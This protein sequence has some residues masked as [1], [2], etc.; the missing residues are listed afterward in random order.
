MMAMAMT[1]VAMTTFF[2]TNRENELVD[3]LSCVDYITVYL[4]IFLKNFSFILPF[5]PG[6]ERR[7]CTDRG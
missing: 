7:N 1:M 5:L 2:K 3:I 6:K 4:L